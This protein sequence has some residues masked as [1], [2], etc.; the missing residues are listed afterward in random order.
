MIAAV[1]HPAGE[2]QPPDQ[3]WSAWPGHALKRPLSS[4]FSSQVP[5]A[6]VSGA[7]V[8]AVGLSFWLLSQHGVRD[9]AGH[10]LES[11]SMEKGRERPQPSAAV[12]R[13]WLCDVFNYYGYPPYPALRARTVDRVR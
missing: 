6:W 8:V 12:E 4:L 10:R 5:L 9:M 2:V 11:P 1:A 7:L 3:R 13:P